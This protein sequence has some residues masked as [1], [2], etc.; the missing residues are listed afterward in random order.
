MNLSYELVRNEML[1]GLTEKNLL[2]AGSKDPEF[3]TL[4]NSHWKTFQ[5]KTL[6]INKWLLLYTVPDLCS[7]LFRK[8]VKFDWRCI[9]EWIVMNRY[10]PN[11]NG[12]I[13]NLMEIP[14]LES[15]NC[16]HYN[17]P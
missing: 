1:P 13:I 11:K 8:W 15:E 10:K 14:N 5:L 7:H 3:V 12:I 16:K 17:I 2:T 4:A 6:D 9:F